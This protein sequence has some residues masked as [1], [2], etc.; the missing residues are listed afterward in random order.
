[1]ISKQ[2]KQIVT[3]HQ[4]QKNFWFR[5]QEVVVILL[6]LSIVLEWQAMGGGS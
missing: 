5:Q 4:K 6:E 3:P 1:M 2:K